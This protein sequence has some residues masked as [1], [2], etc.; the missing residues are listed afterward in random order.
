MRIW[1]SEKFKEILDFI[2]E[3]WSSY[4]LNWIFFSLPTS[5]K[6]N[7]AVSQKETTKK[8][9]KLRW[10]E[11]VISWANRMLR[12]L[13]PN[14]SFHVK[15]I[16][17]EC[18]E[19]TNGWFMMVP[20]LLVKPPFFLMNNK[21]CIIKLPRSIIIIYHPSAT[22]LIGRYIPPYLNNQ[23]TLYIYIT[24][25]IVMAICQ[26]RETGN[27]LRIKNKVLQNPANAV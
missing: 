3:A 12:A 25:N 13:L 4:K 18:T 10:F 22:I 23:P 2:F 16:T 1:T 7:F 6:R 19:Y 24:I 15:R 9:T 14:E 26:C 27:F 20:K 5:W 8:S 21:I 17:A 11:I